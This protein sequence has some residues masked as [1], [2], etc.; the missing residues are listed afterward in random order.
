MAWAVSELDVGIGGRAF[1]RDR[2]EAGGQRPGAVAERAAG[3]QPAK[4]VARADPLA[5]IDDEVEIGEAAGGARLALAA[6]GLA[7]RRRRPQRRQF[8]RQLSAAA[9]RRAADVLRLKQGRL[10]PA[11]LKIACRAPRPAGG[12]T[13]K[14]TG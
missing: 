2:L 4:P 12:R 7:Q 6:E 13:V 9:G 1:A 5:E 3:E 10:V 8:Q 14:K 11:H